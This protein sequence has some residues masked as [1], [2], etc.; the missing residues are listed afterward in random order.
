[1]RHIHGIIKMTKKNL[2][3]IL[4]S[5]GFS[6]QRFESTSVYVHSENK[7]I[8]L[9]LGNLEE[10]QL[11]FYHHFLSTH[12]KKSYRALLIPEDVWNSKPEI[13]TSQFNVYTGQFRSIY[14][15]QCQVKPIDPDLACSFLDSHHLMGCTNGFY[16]CGLFHHQD[17]CGVG[18]FGRPLVLKHEPGEPTSYELIRYCSIKGTVIQGGLSKILKH[19]K[20]AYQPDEIMTSVDL[21]HSNGH[22]FKMIGFKPKEITDPIKKGNRLVSIGNLRLTKAYQY[23]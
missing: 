12:R 2:K 3:I 7:I 15:R 10:S 8:V 13:L 19:F 14:A 18:L 17:L 21:G 4:L 23:E 1:M 20:E 16:P 9:P 5:H 22:S 6:L 11:T